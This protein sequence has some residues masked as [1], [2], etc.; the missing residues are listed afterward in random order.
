M[1]PYRK[2]GPSGLVEDQVGGPD[3]P[4]QQRGVDHPK[5]QVG[6]GLEQLPR[7]PGLGLAELGQGHVV[8]SGKAVLGVPGRLTV[9][10]EDQV[11]HGMSVLPPT[12]PMGE[13][14]AIGKL[15]AIALKFAILT[16]RNS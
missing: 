1:A 16:Y 12:I 2:P 15:I 11:E 13:S 3:R 5:V 6:F 7:L 9:T 4:G 14:I 10:E 8:P